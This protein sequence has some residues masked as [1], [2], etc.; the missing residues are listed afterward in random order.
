M[1]ACYN[2]H[3]LNCVMNQDFS[4]PTKQMAENA[5]KANIDLNDP[6]V[7]EEFKRLSE[8]SIADLRAGKAEGKSV[9]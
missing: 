1:E 9:D 3:H 2:K 4:R 5:K 6:R 7:L 8:E